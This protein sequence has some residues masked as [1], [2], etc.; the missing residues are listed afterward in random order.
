MKFYLGGGLNNKVKLR[1]IDEVRPENILISYWDVKDT[2]ISD[3]VSVLGYKPCIFLDSGAFSAM[4]KGKEI[5]VSDYGIFILNN[6]QDVE[7]YANLDVIYEPEITLYNQKFLEDMG[8]NPL[9]VFH[10]GEEWKWLELYCSK[11]DYIALG[12]MV[13]YSSKK[14]EL[15]KFLYKSFEIAKK[16]KTRI[17]GFGCSNTWLMKS[18]DFYSVDSSSW[19]VAHSKRT[20]ISDKLKFTDMR[21]LREKYNI[22]LWKLTDYQSLIISM[23]KYVEWEKDFN[24]K[25]KK[26][27]WE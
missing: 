13:P 10:V 25:N 2:S 20:F 23:R 4:T 12:G 6:R 14:K 21:I 26:H 17:H 5:K 8:L 16:H 18:F 11:Y 24:R 9:P 22:D 19:L 27:Y 15:L 3:T 1:A 7:T